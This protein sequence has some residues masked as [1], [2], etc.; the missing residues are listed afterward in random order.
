MSGEIKLQKNVLFNMGMDSGQGGCHTLPGTVG[1]GMTLLYHH[2]RLLRCI[3]YIQHVN[4]ELTAGLRNGKRY[5]SVI[6]PLSNGK[7]N[8]SCGGHLRV[9]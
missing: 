2:H 9:C 4:G 7:I 8:R 1:G 3:Q 6:Q 5:A